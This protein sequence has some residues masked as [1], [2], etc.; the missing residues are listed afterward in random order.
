MIIY[1][2]TNGLLDDVPVN[3]VRDWE[4]GFQE[5]MAA[6]YPQVGDRIRT[7]KTLSKEIEADLKRGIDAFKQIARRGSTPARTQQ[8][9]PQ[10]QQPQGQPDGGG[11]GQQPVADTVRPVASGLRLSPSRIARQG[12]RAR[13]I[14]RLSFNLSEAAQ[15]EFVLERKLKGRRVG[16]RCSTRAR[17]GRRCTLLRTA[18]TF[19]EAATAG[20]NRIRLPSRI[21]SLPAGSY[22]LN[23]VA[24]DAAG[25]K[26]SVRR[27]NLT[28]VR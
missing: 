22:R 25:N 10:Q 8:Q 9:Q 24:T 5:F 20:A 16:S 13:P 27:V 28:I 15:V 23:V 6:R 19:D 7:E 11:T 14:P 1:A 18:L 12:R 2:V 17:T 4:R 3:Q 26:S 21:R